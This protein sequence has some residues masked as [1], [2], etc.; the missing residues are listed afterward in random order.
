MA[1][2]ILD[3]GRQHPTVLMAKDAELLQSLPSFSQPIL[4][5]YEWAVECL[6]YGY[7]T[8]PYQYLSCSALE[9]YG[10][11]LAQ[12]PTG[13]G[14]IFHLTDFAFSALVP[15]SHPAYSLNVLDNYAFM[16]HLVI[17]LLAQTFVSTSQLELLVKEPTCVDLA[18]RSFCM[19]KP[20][21]YDVILGGKKV[22]GAAQRRT[23]WGFLHQGSLSLALPP[24]SLLK[25]V[26]K[27]PLVL[28]AMQQNTHALLGS[29][30]TNSDLLIA[31]QIL[32][33][34]LMHLVSIL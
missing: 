10:V 9:D 30:W 23:K 22:G 19:A 21:Q 31:R 15:A 34:K 32:K 13:G 8:N 6:T 33:S 28:E 27:D 25:D 11:E 12:R 29:K 24:L 16:N 26:L 5:V 4:H 1:W 18:C 3:S 2:Y 14:I 17:Q 20:T 7:F